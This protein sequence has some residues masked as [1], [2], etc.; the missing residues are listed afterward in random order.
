[1]KDI[2]FSLS[3][4]SILFMGS[5]QVH[6]QDKSAKVEI[7]IP[8]AKDYT[9]KAISSD[10]LD[11]E[12]EIK[13]Y[14]DGLSWEEKY[15]DRDRRYRDPWREFRYE[16][17]NFFD[18]L[19]RELETFNLNESLGLSGGFNVVKVYSNKPDYH[20]LNI[21]LNSSNKIDPVTIAIVDAEGNLIQRNLIEEFDGEFLG[22]IDLGG[23]AFGTLFVLI[24]QNE[25]AVSRK[26]TL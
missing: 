23:E 14:G 8:K 22:Q 16:S 4:L 9:F 21:H 18:K 1:M 19:G 2:L 26:V 11:K 12:P 7:D 6:A 13:R 5:L 20:I 15:P 10:T 25:Y 17:R 3:F 24:S